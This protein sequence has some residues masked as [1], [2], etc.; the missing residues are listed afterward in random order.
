VI[1]GVRKDIEP[2]LKELGYPVTLP[3]TEGN[4]ATN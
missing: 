3:D 1:V 2:G 4:P